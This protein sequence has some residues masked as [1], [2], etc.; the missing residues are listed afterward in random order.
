MVN[1]VAVAVAAAGVIAGIEF[2]FVVTISNT[3][4]GNKFCKKGKKEKK[5]TSN[6]H[7]QAMQP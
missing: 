6:Y 5:I 7:H 2:Y 3:T 4:S 1:G